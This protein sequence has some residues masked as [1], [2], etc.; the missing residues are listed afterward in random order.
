[1]LSVFVYDAAVCC[2]W[3]LFFHRCLCFCVGGSC[4]CEMKMVFDMCLSACINEFCECESL[5]MC[6]ESSYHVRVC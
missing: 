1:M 4:E 6:G 2:L 3:V 5:R